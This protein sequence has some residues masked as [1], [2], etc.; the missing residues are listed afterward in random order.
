MPY[1]AGF[2]PLTELRSGKRTVLWIRANAVS[3]FLSDQI[4]TTLVS[5]GNSNCYT[6][7]IVAE[8]PDEII[9]LIRQS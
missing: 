3:S 8:T 6:F 7:L 5:V 4:G 9:E 2:I 1:Y